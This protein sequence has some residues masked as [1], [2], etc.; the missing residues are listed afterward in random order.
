MNEST[1]HLSYDSTVLDRAAMLENLGGDKDIIKEL[2]RLYFE[3]LPRVMAQ[4]E[5]GISSNNS[6]DVNMGA[7]A[8]KG[9]S[10]NICAQSVAAR[11]SELE[12]TGRS[13]NLN[14]AE[15]QFKQLTEQ[16]ERL[17]V[18]IASFQEMLVSESIQKE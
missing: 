9:M 5:K 18:E 2:M 1:N 11:A 14:D 10:Y 13:G 7:H 16:I 15:E 3:N 4:I 17:K 8:L 12:K 6:K